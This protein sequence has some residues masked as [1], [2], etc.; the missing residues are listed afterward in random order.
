MGG[1]FRRVEPIEAIPGQLPR[2]LAPAFT[3]PGA[4]STENSADADSGLDVFQSGPAPSARAL[5]L[6]D[7]IKKQKELLRL[8]EEHYERLE[9]Q[10]S[11]RER[12]RLALEGERSILIRSKNEELTKLRKGLSALE[13]L[14]AQELGRTP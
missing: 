9:G 14:L 4:V 11:D 6:V 3:G 12:E 13:S 7:L 5:Q 1:A 8:R 10:F 2:P